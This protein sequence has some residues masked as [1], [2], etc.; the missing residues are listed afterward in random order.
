MRGYERPLRGQVGIKAPSKPLTGVPMV[1]AEKFTGQGGGEVKIRDDKPGVIEKAISH[2]DAKGHWLEWRFQET[3]GK[4]QVVARYSAAGTAKRTVAFDGQDRGAQQF[5]GT[6]GFGDT[7]D[8]WDHTTLKAD[9]KP[10][11]LDLTAGEHVLRLENTD[12]NGLNLD[13]LL[14]QPTNK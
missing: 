14:L 6:G 8:T 2:W 11:V 3:P 5:P 1:Q 7:A 12:G 13:Y 9:G 10:L 4:Y